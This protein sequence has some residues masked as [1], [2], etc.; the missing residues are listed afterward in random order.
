MI[1]DFRWPIQNPMKRYKQKDS[2]LS[3]GTRTVG[4]LPGRRVE[5][6]TD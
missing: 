5:V 6:A 1:L 4:F 2:E 3:E